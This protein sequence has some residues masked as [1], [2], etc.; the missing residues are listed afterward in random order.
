[1]KCDKTTKAPR[2]HAGP[3]KLLQVDEEHGFKIAR[4]KECGDTVYLK[5]AKQKK[6]KR[7]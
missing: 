1:V 2:K 6:P 4:C 5:K 7:S 3:F